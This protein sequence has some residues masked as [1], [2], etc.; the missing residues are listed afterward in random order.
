MMAYGGFSSVM[1]GVL[2]GWTATLAITGYGAL[3]PLI[4]AALGAIIGATV[5]FADKI[6]EDECGR[7]KG[8]WLS[9]RIWKNRGWSKRP[10]TSRGIGCR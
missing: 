1:Y 9:S 4:L 2:A 10:H 3:V 7:R 8:I 6:Y 5:W